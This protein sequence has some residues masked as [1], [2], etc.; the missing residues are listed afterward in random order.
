M[1]QEEKI[2]VKSNIFDLKLLYNIGTKDYIYYVNSR[3]LYTDTF[4]IE[5]VY[6]TLLTI[7]IKNQIFILQVT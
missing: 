3:L 1:R 2:K 4:I 6:K 5:D 7:R